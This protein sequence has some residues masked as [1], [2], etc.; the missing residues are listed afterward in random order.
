MSVR[1]R[2]NSIIIDFRFYLP[3]GRKV[4]CR[5]SEGKNTPENLQR[6]RSKEK[7]IQYHLQNG[8][9]DYLTFFPYGSKASYFQ[10][11]S[12]ELLFHQWWEKWIKTKSIKRSTEESYGYQYE[13]HIRPYFGDWKLSQIT[14]EA[15]II[16]RKSLENKGLTFSTI[17]NYMKPLCQA[18]LNAKKRKLILE[19]PCEDIG[20]LKEAKVDI[21]PFNFQELKHWLDYLWEKNRGLHDMILFWS[22]TG[23]RPGELCAIRWPHIDFFNKKAMIRENRPYYGGVSSPKTESSIRDIDLRP[24]VIEALK[25]QEGRTG[26]IGKWV[27]LNQ[28][29]KQWDASSLRYV[30]RHWLRMA[31]LKQRPPK[32]MR[33]T[34]ATQHLGAGENIS[35]VSKML[36]HSDAQITWKR[37][38]RYIPNLTRDDGSAFEK[39]M[40]GD[41]EKSG[42]KN[43]VF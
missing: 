15:V 6:A 32:Q 3:D 21:D 29:H 16:F 40:N 41:G 7:A 43:V 38:N 28:K 13:N 24:K 31:G 23:L 11:Y 27:F 12:T 34:F 9:F 4:R 25:R 17:N 37:Y 30:F 33:H 5:E 39:I 20:S 2:V 42:G 22:R 26:L 14:E 18:L 10:T 35:W 19:Y 8:S 1:I 36:G